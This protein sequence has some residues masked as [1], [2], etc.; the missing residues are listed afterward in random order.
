MSEPFDEEKPPPGITLWE[1]ETVDGVY[2]S[3]LNEP[4]KIWPEGQLAGYRNA[5][6]NLQRAHRIPMTIERVTDG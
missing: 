6:R 4:E 2:V 5:V 3:N 1:S